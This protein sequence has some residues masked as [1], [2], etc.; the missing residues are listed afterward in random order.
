MKKKKIT[1]KKGMLMTYSN[2]TISKNCGVGF[3]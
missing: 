1:E 2:N 3:L